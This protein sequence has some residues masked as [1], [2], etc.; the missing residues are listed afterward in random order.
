MM[1]PIHFMNRALENGN[2]DEAHSWVINWGFRVREV[3][4]IWLACPLPIDSRLSSSR[5]NALDGMEEWIMAGDLALEWDL[6][7]VASEKLWEGISLHM[8][9]G[10]KL[11]EEAK[12]DLD[13]Y[14]LEP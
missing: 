12:R 13:I 2:L 11:L 6:E 7:D 3:K 9:N 4:K 14:L 10:T 8:K 5:E 1:V